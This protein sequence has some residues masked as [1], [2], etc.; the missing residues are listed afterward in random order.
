MNIALSLKIIAV[1][2]LVV[3]STAAIVQMEQVTAAQN[4]AQLHNRQAKQ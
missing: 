2:A 1:L 4:H 3:T